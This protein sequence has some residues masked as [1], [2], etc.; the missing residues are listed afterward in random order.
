[1]L[2]SQIEEALR[3]ALALLEDPRLDDASLR[4]VTTD[5][6]ALRA[7]VECPPEDVLDVDRA[8]ARAM[9]RIRYE[10]ASEVHRKRLPNLRFVVLPLASRPGGASEEEP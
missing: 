9:P 2:S 8:L 5:G 10:L 7:T 4:D 6:S 3:L 1:M